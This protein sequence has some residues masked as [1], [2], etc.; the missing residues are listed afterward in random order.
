MPTAPPVTSQPTSNRWPKGVVGLHWVSAFLIIAL[1]A[2]GF[3]MTGLDPT[4]PMRR[5][6]GR[7]HTISGNL[8]GV[9]TLARLVVQRRTARPD[10]LAVPAIHQRGI[11]AV[12][13]LLYVVTLGVI[14][15]GLGT[16]LRTNWHT[17]LLGELPRPPSF[18]ALASRTVHET[19]AIILVL[20]VTGHIVG[21]IVQEVR[22]GKTLRR[23]VPF[24]R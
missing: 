4:D 11:R 8:L 14:A 5:N 24:L 9:I 19:L 22:K 23:M 20:L 2:A 16:V 10:P 15:T 7:L 13:A 6:L 17:Y 1:V 18:D 3:L 12:H 21:V